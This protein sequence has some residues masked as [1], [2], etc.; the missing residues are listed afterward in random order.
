M[1]VKF[2]ASGTH[3]HKGKLKVRFDLYPKKENKTYSFHRVDKL[4]RDYTE[5]EQAEL[6][7]LTDTQEFNKKVEELKAEIGTYK[8]TNPC[9]CHFVTIDADT[10]KAQLHSI[11]QNIFDSTTVDSLD[12]ALSKNDVGRVKLIMSPKSG[13]VKEVKQVDIKAINARFAGLEVD[14]GY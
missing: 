2:N 1:I 12:D 3:L 5:K 14:F 11:A 13:L 9:L 10:T 8:G 4:N 6:D 7:A